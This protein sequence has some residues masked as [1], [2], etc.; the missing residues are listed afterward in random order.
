MSAPTAHID[1]FVRDGL[2]PVAQWPEF[3]FDLPELQYP[4]V[5][6][7][8]TELLDKHVAAGKA[9]KVAIYSDSGNW[10]YGEL[11]K[12]SNQ[13]ANVLTQDLGL[14]AGNRVILRAANNPMLV[15]CWFAVVKA[16]GIV[17]TTMPMLRTSELEAIINKGKTSI[18]LVDSRLADDLRKAAQSS[19]DLKKVVSWGDGELE[20]LMAS[21]SDQFENVK[22]YRDDPCLLAFTSGTTGVPKAPVHFHR[23]VLAMADCFARY[24][25]KTTENDIYAG[26]PP[27][28][29]TFG[30][31]AELIFPL[32]F[33]GSAVMIEA[34]APGVLLDYVQKYKITGLFTAPTAYRVMTADVKKFDISSLRFCVS[35]GEPLPKPT[36]DGWFEATGHRIIDG[37]GSTEMIHI[38]ISAAGDEIRPGATGKPVPGYQACVLDDENQPLP[39]GSIGKLAVKGPT[40]CRYLNDDRQAN[41]VANGWNVTGDTYQMDEDGYF[42]FQARA[43][44][45]IISSGYNI[46]GPEVEVALL[47]HP[48]VKETGVVSS[49]D[50]DRGNIV[51]AYIVLHDD[52]KASPELIKILQDHVKN[53]IAPF[54]YPRAIEFVDSLPKTN[55]GKVQ[56][57]KL[58][59]MELEKAKGAA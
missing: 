29:F 10:T 17:V 59:E 48:A 26:S 37:I 23:D 7:C 47:T 43:D 38:F 46:A 25:L 28:A 34:P 6:N 2:P 42:W 21:K 22:T 49:P 58:R 5:L 11:L 31:G 8:A 33:G 45:M 41:Y 4:E 12:K 57:F 16:G 18:G 24:T 56:R 40:G 32:R 3:L 50:E 14:V 36:S 19:K 35:A 39:A 30:L 53:T 9:N 20:K 55:T 1:T 51:K 54:K 52:Q 15:A 44:D 27:L 13:I